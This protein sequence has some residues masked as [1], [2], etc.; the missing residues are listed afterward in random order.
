MNS[1]EEP[2]IIL[3]VFEGEDQDLDFFRDSF[4]YQVWSYIKE[5]KLG[6]VHK[7]RHTILGN[8]WPS[9]PHRFGL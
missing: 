3:K 4:N 1:R 9:L 6:V 7:V 8:I 5:I 2:S